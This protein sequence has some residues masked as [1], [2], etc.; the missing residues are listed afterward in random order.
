MMMPEQ[1]A[2]PALTHSLAA[3]LSRLRAPVDP[4]CQPQLLLVISPL[5]RRHCGRHF[6]AGR[7]AISSWRRGGV[8][9]AARSDTLRD[10]PVILLL[11]RNES[12]AKLIL[13]KTIAA[14]AKEVAAA[15]AVNSLFVALF[16]HELIRQK[17]LSARLGAVT[18]SRPAPPPHLPPTSE[19]AR[20]GRR[21]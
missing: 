18:R 2:P 9:G 15:A 4:L 19:V 17:L 5:P 16:V 10:S 20:D 3:H 14:A 7:S 6:G 1:T 12:S 13:P 8:L 21:R 11:Y